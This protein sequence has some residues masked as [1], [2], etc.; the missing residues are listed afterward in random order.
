[1]V[2]GT[3]PSMTQL[4]FTTSW[5]DTNLF[6]GGIETHKMPI[7]SSCTLTT[8]RQ[9]INWTVV[10]MDVACYPALWVVDHTTWSVIQ[11]C[12]GSEGWWIANRCCETPFTVGVKGVQYPGSPRDGLNVDL[13]CS[14][15]MGSSVSPLRLWVFFSS[16]GAQVS[17]HM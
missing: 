7:V 8:N 15:C 1:M 9:Y 11:H 5:S 12:G 6:E 2:C 4:M 14:I 16:G 17:S 3:N 10:A 13:T